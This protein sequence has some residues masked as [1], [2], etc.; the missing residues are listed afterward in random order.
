MDYQGW[1]PIRY[2]PQPEVPEG[3][4]VLASSVEKKDGVWVYGWSV[5]EADPTALVPFEI[6]ILQALAQLDIDGGTPAVEAY[7]GADDTPRLEKLAWERATVVERQSPTAAIIAG[8]LKW[9]AARVDQFFIA[10]KKIKL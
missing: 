5:V 8:I 9:D 2:Q 1:T 4:S 6:S 3:A 10:A 7:F